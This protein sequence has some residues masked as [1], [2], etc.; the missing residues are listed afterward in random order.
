MF[1]LSPYRLTSNNADATL[2]TG[3]G[4]LMGYLLF[5]GTTATDVILYDNTAASGTVIAKTNVVANASEFVDLTLLGGVHFGTGVR[6]AITGT[7]AILYIWYE[8]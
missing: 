3:V 1:A 6:L 5:G 8:Q 7:G 4:R 2:V